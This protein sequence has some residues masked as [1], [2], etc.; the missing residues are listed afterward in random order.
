MTLGLPKIKRLAI[1]DI[2]KK[3]EGN[4]L[5][6]GGNMANLQTKREQK[7]GV[8]KAKNILAYAK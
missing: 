1:N 6:K 8:P 4:F 3:I 7:I 5:K 2:M